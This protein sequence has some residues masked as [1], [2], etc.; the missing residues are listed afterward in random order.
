MLLRVYFS[1]AGF[2][3]VA[4][5]LTTNEAHSRKAFVE[6]GTPCHVVSA[7]TYAFTGF[8]YNGDTTSDT[9]DLGHLDVQVF[10]H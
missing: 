10:S 5:S 3:Q 8:N 2:D 9:S 4:P 6:E 7:G 1:N